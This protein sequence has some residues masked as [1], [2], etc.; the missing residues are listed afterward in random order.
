MEFDP[1]KLETTFKAPMTDLGPIEGR[2]YTL[3][4]S[5]PTGMFFLDI[6]SDYNYSAV[7]EELRD[8]LLG[9]YKR[10]GYN[11]YILIL[12]AYVG[13]SD[14]FAASMK[15][16][17]FKY[18]LRSLLQAIFYGDKDLLKEHS[19]LINTPVYVKFD[20]DIAIFDNYEN[21]GYIGDYIL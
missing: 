5:D 1:N 4:H 7:D 17:A 18:N 11:S 8:E 2:K 10:Y 15:Y 9:K 20:C 21:Y 13:D 6:G 19:S 3:T 12:Y 16:G 14:Y